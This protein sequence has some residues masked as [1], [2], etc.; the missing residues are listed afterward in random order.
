MNTTG[1]VIEPPVSALSLVE[2][3]QQRLLRQFRLQV[4]DWQDIC[5]ELATWEDVYLV[6]APSDEKLSQHRTNL[7]ELERLGHWLAATS[8]QP[9]FPESEIKEQIRLTL[10]DLQDT[11]AMW[12][13]RLSNDHKDDILAAIFP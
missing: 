2:N 11:R 7:N 8:N 13:Q 10:Q 12:R 5:R 4:A 1:S 6:D 9:T 3:L